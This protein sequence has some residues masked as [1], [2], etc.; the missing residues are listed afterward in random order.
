MVKQLYKEKKF[1]MPRTARGRYIN[2]TTTVPAFR[3]QCRH[4]KN[5]P[6]RKQSLDGGL[7][8]L[9]YC[10]TAACRPFTIARPSLVHRSSIARPSSQQRL[11]LSQNIVR[12]KRICQIQV[13]AGEDAA[14]FVVGDG[15]H[16]H[17]QV[18]YGFRGLQLYA[19]RVFFL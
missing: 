14:D 2:G 7:P 6:F 19:L 5:V 17:V 12:L 13:Y 18:L 1:V 16:R 8:P 10:L 15:F 11:Q 3:R 4:N 9:C